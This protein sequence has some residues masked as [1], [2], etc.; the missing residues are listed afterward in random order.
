MAAM[1]DDSRSGS[2]AGWSKPTD[3][4][5]VRVDSTNGA[6]ERR[7]CSTMSP[8]MNMRRPGSRREMREVISGASG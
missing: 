8:V 6:R 7:P 5:G 2:E 1:T 3:Q 4:A